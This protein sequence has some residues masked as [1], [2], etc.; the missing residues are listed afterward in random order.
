MP[1]IGTPASRRSAIS[2]SRPRLADPLHRPREGADAGQDQAVG[3][4]DRVGVAA[5]ARVGADVLERL[6]DRAQVAHP[7]VED[8]D[9]RSAHSLSVPLVEGTPVS[10]GSIETATPQRPGEGLEARL[11]HVVGVGAV[12]DRR[13][14]GSAWRCWRRRGR[15][16]RPARSRSRRSRSPAGRRRRRSSGRPEMSIAHSASDSSI[17]TSGRAVA[18]DPGAVAERLVERLPEHDADVLDGVVGAGLEVAAR[19]RPRRPRRPWRASRSSMWSRKPT[20]VAA[21]AS[22][23]VEV[24]RE[25]D[26]GL[27][28]AAL[29]CSAVRLMAPRP[30][31]RRLAVHG[32]ALGA[33]DAVDVRRE[34]AAASAVI[35]TVDDPA[36]EG[37]PGRAGRRSGRRR[38]SAARGWSRR[39]SRRRRWRRSGRRRRS[40]R[41]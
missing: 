10:S 6:L 17:G 1:R 32:E 4:A 14:A 22:P 23:A 40:P 18:A 35:S 11:D 13:R 16:P 34:L 27:A 41:S 12:A 28:G 33:G 3:G 20:P 5:D 38:R 31:H 2:S 29:L 9:P 24:E 8:R 19:P 37:A 15:T 21:L 7:V 39:R 30:N 36:A 26:L 25:R